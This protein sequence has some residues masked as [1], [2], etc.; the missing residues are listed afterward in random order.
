[1]T[2]WIV[3]VCRMPWLKRRFLWVVGPCALAAMGLAASPVLADVL[4]G[5]HLL[6]LSE[7]E[8]VVAVPGL[9]KLHRAIVGPKGLRGLWVLAHTSVAG[10]PFE[11]TFFLKN[12][13]VQ[14]VEQQW[15]SAAPVCN[16]PLEYAEVSKSLDVAYG[17]GTPFNPA[18]PTE[19]QQHSTLW[20]SSESQTIAYLSDL[21]EQ[22]SIRIVYQRPQ[23]KDAAEL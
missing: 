4:V 20:T 5:S 9:S 6:G 3:K 13:Q 23:F 11:T 12:H 2:P 16:S 14:R 10:L 7:A 1:M 19:V 22:C 21:P 8:L 17:P 15:R 18:T